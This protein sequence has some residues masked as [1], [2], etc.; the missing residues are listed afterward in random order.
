MELPEKGWA[1][2]AKAR[3]RPVEGA[4]GEARAA[5]TFFLEY[6][7]AEPRHEGFSPSSFPGKGDLSG[8][9]CQRDSLKRVPY[10]RDL[11]ALRVLKKVSCPLHI[12]IRMRKA[13][14]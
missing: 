5:R 11:P 10:S 1:L 9:P 6:P 12:F 13:K 8:L 3:D 7:V 14:K 4:E 2:G